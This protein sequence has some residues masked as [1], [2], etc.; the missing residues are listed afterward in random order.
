MPRQTNALEL[1]RKDHRE[2]Q[3]LFRRFERADESEKES[4]AR[5]V[6]E[7]LSEHARIEEEVFYPYLREATDRLDLLEEAA[8]EH[9]SAKQLMAEIRSGR[10]G[11]HKEA[12]VKVLG[13]YVTH[14]I[15]EEE[16]QI[17]PLVE[18]LGVDL[19]A[20]GMELLERKQNGR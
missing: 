12:V 15:Q 7:A 8:V 10:D 17:F 1:L 5:E 18:K 11:V 6:V 14:H 3:A 16:E 4:L 9:K 20:L 2:V 19:D 13:E